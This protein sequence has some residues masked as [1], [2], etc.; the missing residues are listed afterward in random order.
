VVVQ[1][2][3]MNSL[4]SRIEI[5]EKEL[6]ITQESISVL[7]IKEDSPGRIRTSVFGSKGRKD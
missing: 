3:E 5:I 2:K 7:S 1:Q 4:L 6:G